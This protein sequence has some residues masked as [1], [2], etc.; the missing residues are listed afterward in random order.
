MA[1]KISQEEIDRLVK[2]YG[3]TDILE[4]FIEKGVPEE[5]VNEI[6]RHLAR[7][8]VDLAMRLK[9]ERAK[10]LGESSFR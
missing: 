3:K 1:Q 5:K 9:K 4:G 6:A 8:L 10:R 2:K 7:C